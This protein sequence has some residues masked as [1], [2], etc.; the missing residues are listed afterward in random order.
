MGLYANP[1]AGAPCVCG[2]LDIDHDRFGFKKA[3]LVPGCGCS[4]LREVG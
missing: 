1:D 2:H 4:D 3:C